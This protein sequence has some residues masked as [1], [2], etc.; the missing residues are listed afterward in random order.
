MLKTIAIVT[1]LVRQLAPVEGAYREHLDYRTVQR[2]EISAELAGAWDSPG[3]SGRDYVLMGPAS[4]AEVYLRFVKAASR[5][6]T[7]R[8][9][10][11]HGWN[12]TEILVEDP[13]LL[14]RRLAGSPFRVIGPPADLLTTTDSPRAMQVLGPAGELLYFTRII[15]GGSGFDLG[16]ASVPVDRVFITVVGGPSLAELRRFYGQVLGLPLGDDLHWRIDVLARAH[17]L[18]LDTKFPLAVAILPR[19]FLVE[20]DEYP[21][22][23][24]PRKASRG[25]PPPGMAIVTFTAD[26][27]DGTTVQWRSPP[28][29][30]ADFPYRGRRVAVTVGPAG[31]WVEVVETPAEPGSTLR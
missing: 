12:A 2:G 25:G 6:E 5:R 9:F 22:G 14:A 23:A 20:M 16:A 4:G 8:P 17:R 30:V 28:R 21:A 31:E 7:V 1:L 26:S 3:M 27:L 13:D 11:T 18:P 10:M 19:D 29:A 15:P 24:T